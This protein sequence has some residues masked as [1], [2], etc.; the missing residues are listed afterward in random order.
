MSELTIPIPPRE[1][2]H[3]MPHVTLKQ[4]R[5]TQNNICSTAKALSN[6]RKLL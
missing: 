5:E 6:G 1:H 2:G 4:V 3:K